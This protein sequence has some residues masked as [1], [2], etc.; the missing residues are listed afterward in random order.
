ME[1]KKLFAD[2]EELT[3]KDNKALKTLENN[4]RRKYHNADT[5]KNIIQ[6]LKDC[7]LEKYNKEPIE[8]F[9]YLQSIAQPVDKEWVV[10]KEGNL[11]MVGFYVAESDFGYVYRMMDVEDYNDSSIKGTTVK[12]AYIDN[13]NE[14]T[15]EYWLLFYEGDEAIDCL[16]LYHHVTVSKMDG[17]TNDVEIDNDSVET[18]DA[19]EIVTNE[20]GADDVEINE[21]EFKFVKVG[22]DPEGNKEWQVNSYYGTTEI[23]IAREWEK[24]L[25]EIDNEMRTYRKEDNTPFTL[26]DVREM[27]GFEGAVDKL[28]YTACC[29]NVYEF[30]YV[31]NAFNKEING[32]LARLFHVMKWNGGWEK[33]TDILGIDRDEISATDGKLNCDVCEEYYKRLFNIKPANFGGEMIN[34][35]ELTRDDVIKM[36]KE[37]EDSKGHYG[38]KARSPL[39]R[40][41]KKL[42]GW[43]VLYNKLEIKDKRLPIN[44]TKEDYRYLVKNHYYRYMR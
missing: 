5:A 26:E 41:S 2:E 38:K 18:N 6:R 32:D 43:N 14:Y 23:E 11:L 36:I 4:K 22:Y 3:A 20:I 27:K 7:G 30:D 39:A 9:A 21:A 13:G 24:R 40:V 44:P 31:F 12:L 17:E 1:F 15:D 34:V 25:E 16:S 37:A 8:K 35:D 28:T 33:F 10:C 29:N 19:D 42:G